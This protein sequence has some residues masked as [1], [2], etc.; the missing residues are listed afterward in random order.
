M[1]VLV[2]LVGMILFCAGLHQI[3]LARDEVLFWLSRF[4]D[5]F[6]SSLGKEEHPAASAHSGAVIHRSPAYGTLQVVGGL[7]LMFLGSLLCLVALG[8]VILRWVR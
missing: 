3:W 1:Y 8:L 4:A 5:L 2:G 7:G 6:R